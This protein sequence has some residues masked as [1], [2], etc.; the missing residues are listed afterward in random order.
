MPRFPRRIRPR[1]LTRVLLILASALPLMVLA[2]SEQGAWRA[3]AVD[4]LNEAGVS[5]GFP[6]GSFLAENALTG[7][8]AAFLV[9]SLLDVIDERTAAW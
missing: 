4:E 6:D 5:T 1:V 9:S 3:G 7:Y 8:Q 2:Q